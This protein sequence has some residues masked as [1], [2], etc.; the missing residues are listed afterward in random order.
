EAAAQHRLAHKVANL[1]VEGPGRLRVSGKRGENR[2]TGSSQSG[3]LGTQ[4]GSFHP[5]TVCRM[6]EGLEATMFSSG[7]VTVY[8]SNMDRAVRFYTEVLGLKLAYRFGDH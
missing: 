5:R 6:L 3:T 8:V 2:L 1:Q 4:N 7:N